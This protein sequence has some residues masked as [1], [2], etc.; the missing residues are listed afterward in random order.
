MWMVFP[1]DE[2]KR[3]MAR[4]AWLGYFVENVSP[5][6]PWQL[7]A[8]GLG[9]ARAQRT[10]GPRSLRN[11]LR[12]TPAARLRAGSGRVIAGRLASREGRSCGRTATIRIAAR[13]TASL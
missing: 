4:R 9:I 12:G 8:A 6:S 13:L 1:T 3:S 7:R 2:N 11:L 5:V 10:G